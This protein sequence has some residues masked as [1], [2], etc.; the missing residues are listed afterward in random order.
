MSLREK[1]QVLFPV[2]LILFF[3]NTGISVMAQQGLLDREISIPH[4][5]G[6]IDDLLKAISRKG[7]F[8]FTYTS[9]ID[10]RRLAS[11]LHRKQTVRQHLADIFRYDSI[12]ILEQNK[13]ILLIPKVVRLPE[14]SAFR[15]VRG[16]VIDSRSHRPLPYSSIFLR[17]QS[18]GTIAN[19]SGRFEIKLRPGDA[20]D[21]LGI[22]H[23]GYE[24][25]IIPISEVDSG[26]LVVRLSA[27]RMQIREI[28][29]K[30]MDPIY[31]I[32]K[33]MESIV[34]NYDRK[35]AVFTGFFREATRQDNKN[36]SLS[37][38]V[39]TVYKEPCTSVRDDQIKIFKGRKGSNTDEKE[40]VDFIVEGGLYNTLQLDIVKNKPT[41]LD[42]DY[43][44]LYEY[45]LEKVITHF[46]RLTYVIAFDQREGVKY[47]CYKG[48]LF[49]D[50][51][52]LAI[53]GA[54]FELPENEMSY[55]AGTYVR[56]T[57]RRTG[58][59]PLS[60]RYEVYYRL[61]NSR[62][63]LSNARS[64]VTMRVRRRKDKRQDKFNS[65]FSSVSE[66]VITSKDTVNIV[67][68]KTGEVSKPRDVLEKQIG[69]T[70]QEFWGDENIIIPEEPL[71][72]AI[73]RLGKRN[74]LFTE[75][76][77]QAIRIDEEKEEQRTSEKELPEDD[78]Q[79]RDTDQE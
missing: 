48:R 13:K 77:I 67:R 3:L 22:S 61:Y 27:E 72:K 25:K 46:N 12:T 37:E 55:A 16:I 78:E 58:V 68:F 66:F 45:Q 23:M 71:E 6:E 5:T 79:A 60:A 69:E 8:S 41:F 44:A 2:L 75:R 70:D 33:A 30:P 4:T 36:V 42:A 28:V 21:T 62:W 54:S 49:I 51:E 18:K 73:T 52:T 63:N 24:M 65:V 56:K 59:K 43:F 47:P 26:I 53:V 7:R 31:I 9:Q 39:I 64:E 38:A 32:T 76:E 14:T 11:V 74:T 20:L 40:F 19:A 57:P 34:D 10:T 15:S 35:A 1:Y 29:V 17:N 50:V